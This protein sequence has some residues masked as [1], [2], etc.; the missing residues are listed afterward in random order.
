MPGLV[1]FLNLPAIFVAPGDA[2]T[3]AWL[4]VPTIALLLTTLIG[5]ALA[6]I[7]GRILRKQPESM[8]DPII[9]FP[10]K[11]VNRVSKCHLGRGS[12][13]FYRLHSCESTPPTDVVV[14][15]MPQNRYEESDHVAIDGDVRNDYLPIILRGT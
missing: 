8:V 11:K 4:N 12:F 15:A 5:L 2:E 1:D 9:C 7:V 6:L 14:F 3:R 13:R 10:I